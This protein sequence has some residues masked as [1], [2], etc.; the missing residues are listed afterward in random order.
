MWRVRAHAQIKCYHQSSAFYRLLIFSSLFLCFAL[1][2]SCYKQE[3]TLAIITVLDN[4]TNDPIADANV[5]LFYDP[6][7][8][9][10]I[11]LIDVQKKTGDNGSASFDFSDRYQDGQAGFA[12]LDIE[13]DSEYTFQNICDNGHFEMAKWYLTINPYLNIKNL[14]QK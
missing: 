12:V 10:N 1:L 7:N 4:N 11:P 9:S 13:I 14:K 3:K 6:S 2:F 5:R 8:G